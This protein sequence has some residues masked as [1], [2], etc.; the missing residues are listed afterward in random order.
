MILYIGFDEEIFNKLVEL[1]L[2]YKQKKKQKQSRKNNW[3]GK[4]TYNVINI[5]VRYNTL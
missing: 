3:D 2:R 1:V 4:I 5:I